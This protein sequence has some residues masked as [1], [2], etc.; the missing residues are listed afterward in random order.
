MILNVNWFF[1]KYVV[2]KSGLNSD[3]LPSESVIAG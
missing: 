1:S 2:D 3:N